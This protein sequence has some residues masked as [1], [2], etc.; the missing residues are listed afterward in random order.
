[1]ECVGICGSDVHYW[2]SG[3]IGEFIV[4]KPMVLGHESSG[5]VIQLGEDVKNLEIGT[6]TRS[7]LL[8]C[9]DLFSITFYIGD[10]VAIEPGVPCRVCQYCKVGRYNLCEDIFFCATPPDDGNLSRYYV[11]AADFCFKFVLYLQSCN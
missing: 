5:T 2:V 11:H 3:G 1:M 4:R 6:F 7:A 10:R 9:S 8:F